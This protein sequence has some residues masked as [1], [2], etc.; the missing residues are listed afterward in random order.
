MA[1]SKII[2]NGTTLMDVTQDT[3]ATSNLIS[4]NTAHNAAG[5]QIVGEAT[6]GGGGTV[7]EGIIINGGTFTV[8][9]SF[10]GT[11]TVPHG[12]GKKPFAMC[13]YP[14]TSKQNDSGT[15]AA[16]GGFM[17]YA[18][19]DKSNVLPSTITVTN[20]SSALENFAGFGLFLRTTDST[21]SPRQEGIWG[22]GSTYFQEPDTT[23]IYYSMPSSDGVILGG[24]TYGWWA[25]ASDD[26]GTLVP[27]GMTLIT[28]TIT[29]NGTYNAS[30][31]DADGYSSVT[32]N[33][34]SGGGSPT[35]QTKSVSYTPTE[36]AQSETVSADTGYDGLSSVSVSV[37]A[38]SS[39]YVGSGID[40]RDS[41]DLTV[42][43]GTVNVPAG[44]YASAG[45]K[46]VQ[47]MTLPS[48]AAVSASGSLKG[49]IELNTGYATYLNI[50][51][52]Y[53][54]TSQ[55]YM[56]P[57]KIVGTEG[58][59]TATKGTVSN[60]SVSVTPSV[61]NTAGYIDGSTKTGTAVTV[62]AS[63]LVSGSQ[64]ITSNGTV[65]VTNLEE[66]VVNV[67]G[68]TSKAIQVYSGVESVQN[69]GYKASNVTLTVA[70]TGTYNVSWIAWRSSSQGTM[71]TNLHVNNTTGTNQQ[72]FTNTYGQCITLSNQSYTAGDV[73]TIYGTSGSNSRLI[74]IGNL[75][76]Q[77]V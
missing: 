24:V 22:F 51:T 41:T 68:S 52:G 9:S 65:D 64:T 5:I 13:I 49:Q 34:S 25:A 61:T 15:Y 36:T 60:H 6:A 55:Y 70:K 3:V 18:L 57:R 63:E 2:Y 26:D 71:G 14:I 17:S 76:I 42:S 59:P 73:L 10:S 33:V 35:L 69:N 40:R 4:P 75:I 62:S 45:S 20:P 67:S 28:K 44:Y 31:D 7:V 38:I 56:I 47:S 77:E 19:V 16:V 39:T 72:T 43:G 27:S 11:Q 8:S 54:E 29:S 46:A 48:S 32:V 1:F 53:N 66:V 58:T 37:G 74:W 30:S 50:P 23:N 21:L 12:L